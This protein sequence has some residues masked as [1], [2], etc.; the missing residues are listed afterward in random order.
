MADTSFK[1][2]DKRYITEYKFKSNIIQKNY[3][4]L[5]HRKHYMS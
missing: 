2:K 5:F 4:K 1:C 3:D